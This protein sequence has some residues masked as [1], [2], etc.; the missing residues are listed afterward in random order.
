MRKFE[1]KCKVLTVKLAP[2]IFDM[3]SRV[4]DCNSS[5]GAHDNTLF[6]CNTAK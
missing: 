3:Q 5:S 2:T 1:S 6:M 4:K